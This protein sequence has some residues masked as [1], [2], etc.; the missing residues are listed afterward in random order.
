MEIV[1]N[2]NVFIVTVDQFSVSLIDKYS[3][4]KRMKVDSY[5][6]IQYFYYMNKQS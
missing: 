2:I 6:D 3:S 5:S 4:L 1:W